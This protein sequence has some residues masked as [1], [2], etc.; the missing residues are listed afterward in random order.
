MWLQILPGIIEEGAKRGL[1]TLKVDRHTY[2]Q[3]R[4]EVN[5]AE[6]KTEFPSVDAVIVSGR[7]ISTKIEIERGV[8][9]MIAMTY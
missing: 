1:H 3:I 2:E 7:N 4:Q 5:Q 6:P 8:N 9:F